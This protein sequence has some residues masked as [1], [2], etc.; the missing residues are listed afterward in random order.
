MIHSMQWA[1]IKKD[2]KVISSDKLILSSLFIV[3]AFLAGILPAIMLLAF[4]SSSDAMH[5]MQALINILP[6]AAQ[7]D[8]ISVFMVSYLINFMMPSFFLMIPL[9]V[10][11]VFAASS[12]VGEKEKRTLE[13]LLYCPLPLVKIFQAKILASFF[14]GMAAAV[15]SFIV[16]FLVVGI[17]S[18]I[19][20][21]TTILPGLSWLVIMLMLTPAIAIIAITL[22]V[23]SSARR[24]A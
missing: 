11:M 12:F 5:D 4:T 21:G 15:V 17:I 10:S 6:G 1:I 8:N 2:L 24:K 19:T 14:L 18:T 20:L 13:T 9:L 23:R 3:P 16:M 7:A 22:V